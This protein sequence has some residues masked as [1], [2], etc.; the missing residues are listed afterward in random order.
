[1]LLRLVNWGANHDIGRSGWSDAQVAAVIDALTPRAKVHVCSERAP[2]AAAAPHLWGG[3]PRDLHHLIG[4]CDAV[5]GESATIAAEA[6]ALGAPALYAGCDFPGYTKRL[7]AEGLIRLV[8]PER[9]DTLPSEAFALLS[10]R[11]AYDAARARWLAD[12]PDWA[13][14]VVETA[15][16]FARAPW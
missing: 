3:P 2:P 8:P 6:A 14:D 7:A 12:A 11:E 13:A 15:G 16:R 5:L 1:M 10:G 9:R 4:H